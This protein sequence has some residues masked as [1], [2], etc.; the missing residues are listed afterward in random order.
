M[1]EPVESPTTPES[2][3]GLL[4]AANVL[5]KRRADFEAVQVLHAQIALALGGNSTVPDR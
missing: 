5:L 2:I 3:G 1:T 4:H